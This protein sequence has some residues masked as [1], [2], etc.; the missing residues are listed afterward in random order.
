[1]LLP[2]AEPL[3][4][5]RGFFPNQ[6]TITKAFP[7]VQSVQDISFH[8]ASEAAAE[9]RSSGSSGRGIKASAFAKGLSDPRQAANHLAGKTG[10]TQTREEIGE[11][12]LRGQ[13]HLT[14]QA[15]ELRR[16]LAF[17]A[18]AQAHIVE[19][20]QPAIVKAEA[21]FK[22]ALVEHGFESVDMASLMDERMGDAGEDAPDIDPSL[23]IMRELLLSSVVETSLRLAAKPSAAGLAKLREQWDENPT[24]PRFETLDSMQDTARRLQQAM[25]EAG[26]E[27]SPELARELEEFNVYAQRLHVISLYREA[28]KALALL[29]A[30]DAVAMHQCM[31]AIGKQQEIIGLVQPYLPATLL[32]SLSAVPNFRNMVLGGGGGGFENEG[33][34]G[35]SY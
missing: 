26:G 6:T 28:A 2:A 29:S 9:V 32:L 23:S 35:L 13:Q 5:G 12:A 16:E 33:P 14:A 27:P 8:F 7:M 34:S 4:R 19:Q 31:S 24:E 25:Q 17:L 20:L 21:A 18:F 15:D 30:G 3:L 11:L 10:K 1:M 22:A